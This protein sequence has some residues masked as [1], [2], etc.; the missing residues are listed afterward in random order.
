MYVYDNIIHA[1]TQNIHTMNADNP[2]IG[3]EV[4][5]SAYLAKV[6]DMPST[7][8]SFAATGTQRPFQV[9]AVDAAGKDVQVKHSRRFDS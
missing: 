8:E 6:M 1:N 9:A 3:T 2:M 7:V 4:R 5:M